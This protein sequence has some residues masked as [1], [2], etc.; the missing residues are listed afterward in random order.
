MKEEREQLVMINA[1]DYPLDI[2]YTISTINTIHQFT[3]NLQLNCGLDH[4][5][6]KCL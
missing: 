1:V 5:M 2:A 4:S 6:D 3:R